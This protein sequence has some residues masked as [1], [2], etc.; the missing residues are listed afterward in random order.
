MLTMNTINTKTPNQIATTIARNLRELRKKDK[1]SMKALAELSGVS[2]GSLKRFESTGQISLTALLK[3]AIVLD[4][5][6][7]FDYLF[8]KTEIL[9]IQ[10]IINGKV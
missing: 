2:Y 7:D 3:L 8:K 4:C 10:E 9:S 5:V 6:D 1:L